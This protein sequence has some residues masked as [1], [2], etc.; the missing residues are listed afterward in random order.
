MNNA[1]ITETKFYKQSVLSPALQ[2]M[3]IAHNFQWHITA[4]FNRV[5]T[6]TNGRDKLKAWSSF[7]ERK[8][9]GR[10]YFKKPQSER[11][12]FVAIPEIGT[13]STHLH[14]HLLAK[15]PESRHDTFSQIAES[16]W[17]Q[18]VSTGSLFVQ[19]IGNTAADLERV[20]AYDIKDI[21]KS[22]NFDN[23]IFSNEFASDQQGAQK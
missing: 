6:T 16:T 3:L 21:W 20:V 7:V 15:L 13:G 9:F 4:N 5:T 1:L 18:F 10:N 2:E 12:F 8:L 19:R 17:K 11:L 14:Y 23:V 22:N